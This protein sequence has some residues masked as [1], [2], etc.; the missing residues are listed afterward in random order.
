M[1]AAP[2]LRKVDLKT[3]KN[4]KDMSLGLEKMFIGFSTGE[5]DEE[6]HVP[7]EAEDERRAGGC[8]LSLLAA[9]TEYDARVD[10]RRPVKLTSWASAPDLCKKMAKVGEQQPALDLR[11]KMASAVAGLIVLERHPQN[12][13]RVCM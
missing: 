8:E 9:E 11:E 6:P 13:R 5:A 4:Y 3:Y 2:Y 10:G 7:T 1:D 12:I